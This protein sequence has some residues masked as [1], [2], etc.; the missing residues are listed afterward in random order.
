MTP[1]PV[2]SPQGL[3]ADDFPAPL[4]LL[5]AKMDVLYWANQSA[6]EWLGYSLRG[7]TAKP[8]TD[9][10]PEFEAIKAAGLRC[11]EDF[12]PVSLFNFDIQIS[13]RAND[14]GQITL[15]PSGD[16]IG[17]SFQPMGT[18][19]NHS[20]AADFAVSSMGR[21]LAHE[22]KNPLAG[23]DGAAQLLIDEIS[24]AEGHA[25]IDLIRSEINR[26]RRLADRMESLGDHDPENVGPINIHVLL[27]KVRM[28]VQSSAHEN[29]TFVESYDPSLP[30]AIGDPDTLMQ[31]L[32][33]L[34][35]N[36]AESIAST[37]QGGE[38]RLETSF[39]SGVTRREEGTGEI[40]QL[41][42]EIRVIDDG[43]GVSDALRDRL[44]QPFITNKPTG[45]GLG[46][47]L[48][49][50]V[51]NA[52]GGIVELQSRPGRTVFS[53]LLPVEPKDAR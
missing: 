48:V 53:I 31:A 23:I 1:G 20:S 50:K 52:H 11:R 49:A 43:P 42:I 46:L 5:S 22:I 19:P 47:A 14:K 24:G 27:A 34:I 38:V 25:L 16:H 33:N 26:I 28:I 2:R 6:Q 13:G 30:S 36:A 15:F 41:P 10:F 44:F 8:I 17:F 7:L 18:E 3:L 39:R 35:K 4:I 32:L 45:Q 40:R 9:I 29:I 51:A 21:M 12:S 37:G